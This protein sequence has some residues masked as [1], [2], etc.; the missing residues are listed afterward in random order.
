MPNPTL[1]EN[2]FLK[3]QGTAVSAQDTMTAAGAVNK[4]FALFALVLLGASAIWLNPVIVMPFIMPALIIGFIVA[5]VT[6]FKQSWSPVT[7]PIY[8]FVEGV[9]LGG[10]S[11]FFE[12]SYPG[13]V[14]QAVALTFA[15]LFCMLAA[16]KA[17]WIKVTQ[18]FRMII[19]VATGAIAMVYLAAWILSFFGKSVPLIFGSGP[20][21]IGFSLLVVGI[22]AFNLALDFDFIDKGAQY[23]LPK[24]MEWYAAFGLMVTL[25]WLYIEIL[26]LLSKIM[27]RD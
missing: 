3:A 7:A 1:G 9:V 4:S 20:I 6:V 19:L 13:I 16:Y 25:I 8:A 17:G 5:M 21:G 23:N 12:K 10:I 14:M 22:A 15:T 24:Y 11:L 26:R 27:G 18:K 2:L